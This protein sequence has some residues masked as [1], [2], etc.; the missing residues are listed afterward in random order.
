MLQDQLAPVDAP[1]PPLHRAPWPSR[2]LDV[3]LLLATVA[4]ATS[5]LWGGNGGTDIGLET[6]LFVLT[7][8]AWI[9]LGLIYMTIRIRRIRRARRGDTRWPGRLAGRRTIY[10]ITLG[11]ALI[12]LGSAGNIIL[13]KGGEDLNS[14]AVRFIGITMVL[15][16]WTILQLAYTERYARMELEN[17]GPAHF[18]FPATPH[19]SLLE[20]AYFAFTVGTTFGTSDVSV[21]TSRMRGVVLCHGLLAFVYNTAVLGMVLSLISG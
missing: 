13:Y 4:A 8:L 16:A 5:A 1:Q 14:F 20:F 18:D 12:V 11:T 3:L 21:Q 9:T 15:V 19:P 7:S 10:L 6:S 2:V 17:T